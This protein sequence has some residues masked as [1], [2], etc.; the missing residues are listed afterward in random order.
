MLRNY[1]KIAWRNIQSRKLFAAIN[2]L[3][4]AVGLTFAL[5]I[6]VYIVKQQQVNASLKNADHQYLLK[7]NWKTDAIGLDATTLGPLAK[8]LHEEYPNLVKNYYRYNP[9]TNV[10]S[11]GDKHL[12]ED[13]AIGD[14]TLVSMYGFPLLHGNPQKAFATPSSAVITAS[15]AKRLFG[16]TDVLNERI[17]VGTTIADQKQ[18]YTISAVLKDIPY[19]SVFGL[20]S[21]KYEVFVPTTSSNYY[22]TGDPAQSWNQIF[23]IGLVELQP[24]ITPR[25]LEIPIKNILK[26]YTDK[27]TQD[28]L[29]VEL[30]PVRSYYTNDTGVKNMMLALSLA[31][32]FI[33]LLAIINYININIGAAT[34]RI[35]EIGLRK[36]FGVEKRQLVLQFMIESLA[37]T[38]IAACISLLIYELLLSFFSTVLNTSF[39]HFWQF[40]LTSILYAVSLIIL[41]GVAAGIY[42][43]FIV[44][45]YNIVN[46]VKGKTK[47]AAGSLLLRKSLLV[48]QFTLAT[49]VFIAAL[50]ISNQIRFTFHKDLGYTREGLLVV[51]AFPKQWD[52]A[53]IQKMQFIKDG[54]LQMPVVK[55]ASISFEIPERKPPNKI[56]I[57]RKEGDKSQNV[58]IG[59]MGVDKDYAAT[60]GLK[61]ISGEFFTQS[62]ATPPNEVVVTSEA[63]TLL[64]YS[65]NNIVGKQIRATGF[66]NAFTI[67][68]VVNDYN[69]SSL[70]D[71]IEPLIFM[72]F[73]D[74]QAYRY[75]TLKLNS[76][77]MQQAI[78]QVEQKWKSLSP[79]SPFE[80][81]FMEDKFKSLY[82][83]ELQMQAAAGMAAV[84]NI[85][86]I[87]MGIFGVVSFTL[88]RR[89]KEI[90]VRKVLGANTTNV[91]LLFI[92]DY[93]LPFVIA[94]CIGW[95]VAYTAT[96]YWLANYAYRI[97][98]DFT[99]YGA[100]TMG[101]FTIVALFIT[102]QCF[103]AARANPVRALKAE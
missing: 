47:N 4:L 101:M 67:K 95:P 56:E 14:T 15:M 97:E 70:H 54:L 94:N 41:V 90:A 9:V 2:V 20:F 53:G 1:I 50:N 26:K 29:Q 57:I 24:N 33:L 87:F 77:N 45:T 78:Q 96:S 59:G 7:S 64:G 28:L 13:I 100:A 88:T 61:I 103:N 46:A 23:E 48:I 5:V 11:A 34:Y 71:K 18:Q 25:H 65:A 6:G 22:G 83:S 17:D 51:T 40:D 74:L 43:A 44:S 16:R 35:K 89:A 63:A 91:V 99:I 81:V 80:Y 85:I 19:N 84:L 72:N 82:K 27:N 75:I 39:P 92:K 62:G 102:A 42:P 12:K 55:N 93:F 68:G 38:C 31:A 36:V 73:R 52:S 60:F 69:H 10:V 86:I 37:V 58:F 32:L 30:A 3:C 66:P 76:A 49:I 79:N 98:Q 8:T 21:D